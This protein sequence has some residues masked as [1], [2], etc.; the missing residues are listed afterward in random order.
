M[1]GS[2]RSSSGKDIHPSRRRHGGQ[3]KGKQGG[4]AGDDAEP[5]DHAVHE[6]QDDDRGDGQ[7][8]RY[9]CRDQVGGADQLAVG[10]A[11]VGVFKV[12]RRVCPCAGG[13]RSF[14]GVL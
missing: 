5:G 7:D 10:D 2:L 6:E 8:T 9:H 4:E 14:F 1:K 11:D 12:R 13:G 3:S